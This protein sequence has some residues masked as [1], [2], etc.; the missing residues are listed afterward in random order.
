MIS[1]GQ[2]YRH[3][4]SFQQKEIEAF[5]EVTG[6]KNPIHLDDEY[7]AST[8]FKR[9]IMQ[10]FLGGSIFSKILGTLFPG[11]GTIYLKQSLAFYKPMYAEEKYEAVLRVVEIIPKKNR[12]LIET[13]VIDSNGGICIKGEALIQNPRIK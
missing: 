7:A 3:N 11:A 1:V 13:T 9:K 6:D 8:I 12:A 5:A 4:F 10:G 2:E